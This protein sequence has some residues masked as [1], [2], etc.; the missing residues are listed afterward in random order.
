MTSTESNPFD[1]GNGTMKSS[2]ISK[3]HTMDTGRGYRNPAGAYIVDFLR[4]YE[5]HDRIYLS[6][7]LIIPGQK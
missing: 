7:S 5:S 6:I 4:V 3:K 1:L 2:V